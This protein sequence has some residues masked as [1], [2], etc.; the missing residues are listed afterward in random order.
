ML[1]EHVA[2]AGPEFS[3]DV[4]TGKNFA[5]F[6]SDIKVQVGSARYEDPVRA[7]PARQGI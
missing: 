6:I 5:R 1:D 7:T 4:T 3:L 2:D